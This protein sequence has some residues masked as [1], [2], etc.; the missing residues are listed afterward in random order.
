MEISQ[1]VGSFVCIR[2]AI[3]AVFTLAWAPLSGHVPV[4]GALI[5]IQ[6][7]G[8]LDLQAAASDNNIFFSLLN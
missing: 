3:P 2:H 6:L 4:R 8:L 5:L 1:N 7:L